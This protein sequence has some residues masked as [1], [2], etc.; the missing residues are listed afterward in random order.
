MNRRHFPQTASLKDRLA[1]FAKTMQ[2]KADLMV[3]GKQRDELLQRASRADTASHLDDWAN[4]P[5]LRSPK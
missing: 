4:S 5:G 2:E 3:P 1:A